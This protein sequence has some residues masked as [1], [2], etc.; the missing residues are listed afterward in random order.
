MPTRLLA[1]NS[2]GIFGLTHYFRLENWPFSR[3]INKN[4]RKIIQYL[5]KKRKEKEKVHEKNK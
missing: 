5:E 1:K 2:H 4:K 3:R